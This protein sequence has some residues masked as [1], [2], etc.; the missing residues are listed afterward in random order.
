VFDDYHEE[1]TSL[2]GNQR[3]VY[4]LYKKN[5]LYYVGLATNLRTRVKHHLK[6]RHAKKWDGFSLY[7]IHNVEHL[8]E[9]ESLLIRIAEPR[10]NVKLGGFKRPQ[11]LIR[12]LKKSMEERNRLQVREILAGRKRHT[13]ASARIKKRSV[14]RPGMRGTPPLRGLLAVDAQLKCTYKEREYT[15][16]VDSEGMIHIDNKV[17]NSPSLAGAHVTRR[18]TNGWTFWSYLNQQGQWVKID[19]L[20]SKK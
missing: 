3:G 14:K 20:R 8:H 13:R 2:I 15:A 5:H 10:G 12:A 11:N 18:Q 9:L 16:K 7:L 1:I 6:D 19:Q 17:Y 4:T